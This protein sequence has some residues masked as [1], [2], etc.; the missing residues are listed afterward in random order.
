[1][2]KYETLKKSGPAL[3]DKGGQCPMEK[4]RRIFEFRAKMSTET[5]KMCCDLCFLCFFGCYRR[6]MEGQSNAKEWV[7]NCPNCPDKNFKKLSLQKLFSSSTIVTHFYV[8][9]NI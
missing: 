8:L 4:H 3:I 5:L 2:A 1:V 6:A 7:A 9:I